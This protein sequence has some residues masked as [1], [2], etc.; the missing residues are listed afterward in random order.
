MSDLLP[1]E[2][3][4]RGKTNLAGDIVKD[5]LMKPAT[6]DK[7]PK[8]LPN[9]SRWIVEKPYWEAFENYSRGKEANPF[10]IL[11]PVSFEHWIYNRQM[12]I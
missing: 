4:N 1:V 9:S 7:V 10:T 6:F 8:I 11:C 3:L 12:L 5:C 2:I